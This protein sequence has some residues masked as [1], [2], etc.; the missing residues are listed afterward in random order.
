[1]GKLSACAKKDLGGDA[2]GVPRPVALRQEPAHDFLGG[3]IG[4]DLGVV[5][6][7]DPGIVGHV[8]QAPAGAVFDLVSKGDPTAKREFGELQSTVSKPAVFHGREFTG[9][10]LGNMRRRLHC[11]FS[12]VGNVPAPQ[13][14]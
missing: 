10:G 13:L 3:A 12:S 2:P 11:S 8:Q 9:V 6:K 1:M 14:F 4:I 5:K 7:V